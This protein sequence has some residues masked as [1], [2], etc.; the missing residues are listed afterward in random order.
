LDASRDYIPPPQATVNTVSY[1]NRGDLV[2]NLTLTRADEV[3]SLQ[4]Q[5]IDIRNNVP[6]PPFTAQVGEEVTIAASNFQNG[7]DYRVTIAG[8]DESG[9][10]L[11]EAQHEFR[12]DPVIREGELQ[13]LAVELDP[14]VPE[15]VVEVSGKDLEGLS[16]YEVW[17]NAAKD[18]TVVPGSRRQVEP[19]SIVQVPLAEIDN[20]TYTIVL[21]AVGLDS[22]VLA[23]TS[24]QNAIYK[25][26][27]FTRLGR[28]AQGN[29]VIPCVAGLILFGSGGLLFKFLYLDPRKERRAG[30]VIL[31]TGMGKGGD[32][33]SLDDWSADAV[34]LNKMRLREDLDRSR[35]RRH[36]RPTHPN[37]P[38]QK[39]PSPAP[40]PPPEPAPTPVP[41]MAGA[42]PAKRPVARLVVLESPDGMLDGRIFSISETPFTLGRTATHIEFASSA[43]SRLHA[44]ISYREGT[45]TIRDD[46]STNGTSLDGVPITGKGDAPLQPGVVISLG[47]KVRLRFELQGS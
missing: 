6:A 31:K 24:Y 3:K 19:G 28:S 40:P 35:A 39:P 32:L 38:G 47:K 36:D 1:S 29:L 37:I 14:D 15:F 42:P 17:L 25:V 16:H 18:N 9:Q 45:Y 5:I 27:L 21:T 46:R 2:L 41:D 13:I 23:E 26:G 30:V 33:E 4:L 7:Q 44:E 22:Q 12:Y 10:P 43:V 34:R 20:G 8:L 11:F